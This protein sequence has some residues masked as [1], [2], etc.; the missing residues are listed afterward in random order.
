VRRGVLAIAMVAATALAAAPALAAPPHRPPASIAAD[1]SADVTAQLLAWIDTV[2]DG[3]T[4]AFKRRGCY[5]IEGTLEIR[6]R[7]RLDF[8][9]NGARFVATTAGTGGRSQ[10]RLVRG[11]HLT[12]RGMRVQGANGAP[13]VFDATLQHQHGFD[14]AGAAHVELRHVSASGVYG[15]C[16]YVGRAHDHPQRWS[17]DVRVRDSRCSGTGRMGVAVVAGRRVAVKRSRFRRIARTVLDI[18]PNGPGF[19]ARAVSFVGNSATG[20]LPGG[21]FS[22]IGHGPVDAV[23]IARNRLTGAGMYMAVLAPPGE[24]RSRIRIVRNRSDTAY[25]APGSAALDFER[26]DRLTVKRNAIPLDGPD[27]ALASV[28]ESCDVTI[29]GNVVARGSSEVRIAPFPCPAPTP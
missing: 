20:P 17:R 21:F 10:W 22:A 28:S 29:F 24:R 8:K 18:E 1:C 23:T 3:S 7:H 11:S 12:L 6:D 9:G 26:I 13:G 27:M 25:R 14:L 15:D 19:G 4:L 2:P 16:V 5:R